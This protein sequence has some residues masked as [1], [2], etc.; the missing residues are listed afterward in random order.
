[1][2]YFVKGRHR[3]RNYLL[4]AIFRPIYK[5]ILILITSSS[6]AYFIIILIIFFY[7]HLVINHRQFSLIFDN[8]SLL[9][10][11]N[12]F[13]FILNLFFCTDNLLNPISSLSLSNRLKRLLTFTIFICFLSILSKLVAND[14][15]PKFSDFILFS[16][17]SF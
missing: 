15:N 7:P 14:L 1:V 16:S 11:T 2:L 5:F 3:V 12:A 13:S 4:N 10:T 9:I 6:Y 8:I 17:M